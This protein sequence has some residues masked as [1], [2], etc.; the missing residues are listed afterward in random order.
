MVLEKRRVHCEIIEYPKPEFWDLDGTTHGPRKSEKKEC[1][2]LRR[3]L[4]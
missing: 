2:G 1:S 4:V 3:E